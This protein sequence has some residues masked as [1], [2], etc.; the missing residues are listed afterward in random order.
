MHLN[1]ILTA[2][3]DIDFAHYHPQYIIEAV[4]ALL[5]L[6]KDAA[7]AAIESCLAARNLDI[8]PGEGLFLV[9][10]T[11]FEVPADPGY[12]PPMRL[13]RSLPAP[14]PNPTSLPHFPLVIIDDRPLM[15]ISGFV[16]GGDTEPVAIH[17]RHF[18]A[19]GILRRS[20]LSPSQSG[21]MV[22]DQFQA[23][24][25]SAYGIPAPQYETILINRQLNNN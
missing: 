20:A 22:A 21:S 3:A 17:I 9:L 4:N 13:G 24:Y 23:I 14:P 25:L 16:L 18:R 5:P 2:A 12:H 7:L 1:E 6:K 8:A 19:N 10:R 15:M 11:L